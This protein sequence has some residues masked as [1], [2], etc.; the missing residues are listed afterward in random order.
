MPK[1]ELLRDD[2]VGGYTL[3]GHCPMCSESFDSNG[4]YG[5]TGHDKVASDFAKHV[6]EKHRREDFKET[7]E[8]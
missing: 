1:I 4:I 7:A 5:R 3:R 6:Q 2:V 8:R